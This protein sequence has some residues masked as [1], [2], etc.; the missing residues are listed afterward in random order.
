MYRLPDRVT[1]L[2]L[3]GLTGPLPRPLRLAARE[4]LLADFQLAKARRA[5]VMVIVHPKSG[6]TWLRVMLSRLYQ[7]KYH[8]PPRRVVKSDEF[9]NRDH[10]LPKFL[11]TN[12]HY[13][14]EGAVRSLFDEVDAAAGLGDKKVILFAR[15]PCDIAVSWFLQFTTRTSAYKRELI[16]YSLARPIERESCTMWEFVMHEELGLPGLIEFLNG[17]ERALARLDE[18]LILRYE[19]LRGEP[20]PTLARLASFIGESFSE[21]EIAEA[22]EFGSF[23]NMRQLEASNYFANSSLSPR[24]AKGAAISKVRRGKVGGFRDYFTAEQADQMDAMV[25]ERLSPTFGYGGDVAAVAAT[26]ASA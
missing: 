4:R 11:F 5:D 22:V 24:K 18:S 23:D 17:W 16:N 25:R 12:G 2:S 3:L 20:A 1:H 6:G 21:A 7:R 26:A 13:A 19:D 15:H 9:Y 8:L 10:A 14:Y